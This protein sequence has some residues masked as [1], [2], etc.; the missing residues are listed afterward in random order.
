MNLS[1]SVHPTTISYALDGW[2]VDSTVNLTVTDGAEWASK[3]ANKSERLRTT[4][5]KRTKVKEKL[6][7]ACG[8]ATHCVV[9][10]KPITIS[11]FLRIKEF[12]VT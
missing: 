3:Q 10:F 12:L 9:Y 8:P 5:M 4:K 7:I 1:V 11:R 6:Q 2:A